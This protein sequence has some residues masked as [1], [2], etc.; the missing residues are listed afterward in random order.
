MSFDAYQCPHGVVLLEEQRVL[1]DWRP[2]TNNLKTRQ[3][4]TKSRRMRLRKWR[5]EK[6]VG[7]NFDQ[8]VTEDTLR[9]HFGYSI[10]VGKV[11]LDKKGNPPEESRYL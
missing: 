3:A 4:L 6:S 5:D 10:P 9:R 8:I 7:I 11:P 2:L 1:R